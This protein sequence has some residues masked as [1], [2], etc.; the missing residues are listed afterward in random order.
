MHQAT[1]WG[2]FASLQSHGVIAGS[3]VGVLDA[4]ALSYG[5]FHAQGHPNKLYGVVT[6]GFTIQGVNMDV[7]HLR[8]IR[9][10]KDDNPASAI[11][12]KPELTQNGKTAAQNRWIAYNKMRGQYASAMEHATPEQFWVDKTQC[13]YADENGNTQNP[14]LPLAN[15][16][17]AR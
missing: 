15:R 2:Y 1:I 12:N 16:P 9:W 11:N 17:S 13:S 4:P 8:H 14:T 5:L 7:G 10:V 3:Q 6:T